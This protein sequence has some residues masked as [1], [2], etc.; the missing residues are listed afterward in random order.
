MLRLA[1][2]AYDLGIRHERVRIAAHLQAQV[3]GARLSNET[4]G[5]M[6][7]EELTKKRPNKNRVQRLEFERAVNH[8]IQEV[9]DEMFNPRGEW[10]PPAST[11]FPDDKH[12][13]EL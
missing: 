5:G 9:I 6:F 12:K 8:R 1:K 10:T 13:G 3:Q 4:I 11:M 2:W 7:D